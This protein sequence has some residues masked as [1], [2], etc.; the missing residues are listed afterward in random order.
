MTILFSFLL[1]RETTKK[2]KRIRLFLMC[3]IRIQLMK[4]TN[5]MMKSKKFK[6]ELQVN[7]KDVKW[8]IWHHYSALNTGELLG[9]VCVLLFS[10]NSP[11]SMLSRYTLLLFLSIWVSQPH[12][13]LS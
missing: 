12:S 5:C 8:V 2:M 10:I 3:I 4:I 9:F 13:D 1:N 6:L 11:A 7:G